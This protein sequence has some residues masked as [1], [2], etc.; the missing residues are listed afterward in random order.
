MARDD[1]YPTSPP[2]SQVANRKKKSDDDPF[3][4]GPPGAGGGGTGKYLGIPEGYSVTRSIQPHPGMPYP[5]YAHGFNYTTQ[6]WG[7]Q[8]YQT[9]AGQPGPMY[10]SGDEFKPAGKDTD[11]I[12]DMQRK[13]VVS[14]YLTVE[15]KYRLGDWDE[16]TINA[17]RTL[18]EDANRAGV[19]ADAM[20][21][22]RMENAQAMGPGHKM[23]DPNT[24]EIVDVPYQREPLQ[25]DLPNRD[26]LLRVFRAA[27]TDKLGQALPD[28]A[29]QEMVDAYMWKNI[30]YQAEAN[31]FQNDIGQA[32]WEGAP[33]PTQ[34]VRE[35]PPSP[36]AFA[37]A[38]AKRR[39]PGGYEAT[40]AYDYAQE[41]FNSIGG[42]G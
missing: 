15:D 8:P 41:F 7:T 4:S 19:D 32:Q 2:T 36:E 21:R 30:Q 33:P 17:Y 14:G 34:L 25:L 18:L 35:Q 12:I 40:Q 27:T 16:P 42:Y 26:D 6:S 5:Q 11:S 38:E 10:K 29:Y 13:L 9:K 23:I 20:V 22:H 39:D 28:S 37:E 24:G 31:Q 3:G 1:P